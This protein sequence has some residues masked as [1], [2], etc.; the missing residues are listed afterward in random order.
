M[1][2]CSR[3]LSEVEKI[4]KEVRRLKHSGG[5]GRDSKVSR[6][7][8]MSRDEAGWNASQSNKMLA[9]ILNV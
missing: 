2:P 3:L 1:A 7:D 9:I 6:M 4:S 8:V 5:R